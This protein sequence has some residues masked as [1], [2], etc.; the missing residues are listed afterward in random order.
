MTQRDSSGW[1]TP[2]PG[3]SV[4]P[5]NSADLRDLLAREAIDVRA[6]EAG[7]LFCNQAKNHEVS[8]RVLNLRIR[9]A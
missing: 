2:N 1:W 3:C 7:A 5:R 9:K 8:L 6:A 4:C